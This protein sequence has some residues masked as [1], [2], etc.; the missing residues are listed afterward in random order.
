MT[1]APFL[2]K[3]AHLPLDKGTDSGTGGS[4]E[5]KNEKS[6]ARLPGT[7]ITKVDRETTDDR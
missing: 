1:N 2:M 4:E 7:F 5:G 6:Q 3:F